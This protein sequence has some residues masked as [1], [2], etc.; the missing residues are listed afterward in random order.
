M[1]DARD[2]W[3]VKQVGLSLPGSLP[4]QAS[5]NVTCECGEGARCLSVARW[6]RAERTAASGTRRRGGACRRYACDPGGS[7]LPDL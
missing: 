5:V 6:F 7:G 3:L 1:W 4:C 2:L